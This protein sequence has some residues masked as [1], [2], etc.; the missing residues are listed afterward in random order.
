MISRRSF[1]VAAGVTP[2]ASV[3]LGTH[4]SQGKPVPVGLEL[5]SLRDEEQ[6]DRMGTLRAVAEMG[7]QGVEFWGPYA[8]WTSA[9]AREVR[10][11]LDALGLLCFSA[12]T[13]AP[14]YSA[15]QFP[16]IIELNQILGSRYVVMAHPGEVQGLDGW[17]RVAETLTGACEKLRPLGIGAG[18]HNHGT[19]WKMVDGTRPID[20]LTGNTPKDF[21]FQLDLG[22]C[23]ASGADPIAFVKANAGRV[24][25]YHLKDWSP[26]PDKG[27]RVL[28]GEG[29]GPWR[30]LFEVA[31]SVGGVEYYL[32]E[33]EGSRF[34]PMETAKLCLENYRKL[35]GA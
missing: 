35:R 7:Y 26:E 23:L 16:H 28:L 8:D 2:L 22:T 14:Y 18:F 15:G 32:I 4:A 31:E 1:L 33:Q 6:K 34:P 12:H 9:Y 20:I 10:Q 3:A 29:I 21:A 11:Q 27:Y 19:E 13:R 17:K 25:S 24:K 5:Y 30:A